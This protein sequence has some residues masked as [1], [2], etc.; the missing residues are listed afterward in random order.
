MA[1]SGPRV[2]VLVQ[3]HELQKCTRDSGFLSSPGGIGLL[4]IGTAREYR[5][6]LELHNILCSWLNPHGISCRVSNIL[7]SGYLGLSIFF[8]VVLRK[9]IVLLN[10]IL[11]E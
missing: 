7:M 1:C 11:S 3:K 9:R 6:A 2:R 8:L 5:V 4:P 10:A